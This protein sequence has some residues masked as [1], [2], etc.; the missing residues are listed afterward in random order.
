MKHV[1]AL[2]ASFSAA[3]LASAP[4]SASI[5][6]SHAFTWWDD[7]GLGVVVTA[8]GAPAPTAASTALFDLR[9]WHLDQNQTQALYSGFAGATTGMGIANPF[10]PASHAGGLTAGS[11]LPGA[12][13]GAEAFIYQLTNRNFGSG[14][15][16]TFSGPPNQPGA[17]GLSGINVIDTHGALGITGP[18]A[19]SQF[20]FTNNAAGLGVLDLTAGHALGSQNDWEFNAFAG[21]GNFEWDINNEPGPAH[22]AAGP[23]VR[24]GVLA[25]QSAIFG[26][27]MPGL[28][29]DAVNNG[30]VHS[31]DLTPAGALI[32]SSQVNITPTMFGFSGPA[33]IPTPGALAIFGLALGAAARRRRA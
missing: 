17:N 29:R 18:A 23:L 13:A 30:W 12:I 27:A 14:N 26:F 21:A 19:G 24:N 8:L 20:M 1:F 16:F 31:W 25:G 28:W 7:P 22:P 32:P 9:E 5:L 33:R 11:V 4:V 6:G 3:M 15:G 2:G 10:N